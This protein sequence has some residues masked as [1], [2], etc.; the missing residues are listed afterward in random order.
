MRWGL[1][2]GLG[3]AGLTLLVGPGRVGAGLA[4]IR[5]HAQSVVDDCVDDPIALRRQ[6]EKLADQYPDRIVE[7]RGEV[8]EVEHQIAQLDR[9]IEIATRVVSYTSD[10]LGNLK[11]RIAR[12]EN[13]RDSC[14]CP[15][16]LRF[17]GIRFDIDGARN[18]A[19]RI[20]SLRT[21]YRDRLAYDQQQAQMLEEQQARLNDILVKLEDDFA[22]YKAQLYTLDRQ[23]DA[24][25][26]NERLIELIEDQQSTLSS[27]DRYAQVD[28][29]QQ[30]ESKL[31]QLRK[32]QDAQLDQL[33][34]KGVRIDY[35]KRA[36]FDLENDGELDPYD[37]MMKEFDTVTENG[38][39]TVETEAKP[40]KSVAMLPRIIE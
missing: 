35:E 14:A 7:V 37:A 4:Q 22:T 24:I 11:T 27:Y 36:R 28:N 18:E 17:E 10:D 1:I 21:N 34:E 2:G 40:T 12:A 15:V 3:L 13:E 16:F 6:L 20:G 5:S 39:D 33:T 23:I 9:D 29:L 38:D 26:R 30:L 31:A 25:A 19:V 8:A 32:L